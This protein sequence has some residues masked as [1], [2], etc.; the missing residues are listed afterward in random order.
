MVPKITISKVKIIY[1]FF[2]FVVFCFFYYLQNKGKLQ[3]KALYSI[4]LGT[5]G[6]Q[7]QQRLG[8]SPVSSSAT[9]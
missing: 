4:F 8:I 9:Q 3:I 7:L 6:R 1:V 2:L 5:P